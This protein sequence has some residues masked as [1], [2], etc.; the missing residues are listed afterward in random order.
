MSADEPDRCIDDV[1]SVSRLRASK[2]DGSDDDGSGHRYADDDE[3]I[4]WERVRL[5][6]C[7]L[8]NGLLR[9]VAELETRRTQL[10]RQMG[11]LAEVPLRLGR[12]LVL[13]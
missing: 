5:D 2:G 8:H 6:G 3:G 12:G 7:L 4:P 11:L 9:I 1:R 10:G 13:L